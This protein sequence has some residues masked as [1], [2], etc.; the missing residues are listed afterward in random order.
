VLEAAFWGL[1][2]GIALLAGAL[3]GLAWRVPRRVIGL[4]MA[5][6]A[7][8]LISAL[9][10]ELT[11]EAVRTGGFDATAAG[12]AAGSLV[13]FLGDRALDRM[14]G[15]DRKRSSGPGP[16]AAALGI[17]LGAIL[18]GIPESAAIGVSMIDGGGVSVA[19]VVAVFLSHVPESLSAAT[20]L[21][22]RMTG[23]Q[24][25]ALWS[26]VAVVSA[27]SAA[28]GYALLGDASGDWVAFIQSFAAGAILTMLA[29]TMIPEAFDAE[30][31]SPLTGVVTTLGFALAALLSTL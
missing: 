24:I 10:F 3:V 16:D 22:E 1:V 26:G 9:S 15:E 12:L 31:R 21:R 29:D 25:I 13:F 4:V 28:L 8:V 11:A 20:G 18:D 6:G 23:G 17:V 30:G 2:G 7:G 27:I 5:F 14:G 19:V